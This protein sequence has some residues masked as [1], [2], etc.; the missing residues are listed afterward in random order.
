MPKA[1][2]GRR[3]TDMT[4]DNNHVL[5][6]KLESFGSLLT[7]FRYRSQIALVSQLLAACSATISGNLT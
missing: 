1:H 5:A 3:A 2:L 6:S 4:I 7:F